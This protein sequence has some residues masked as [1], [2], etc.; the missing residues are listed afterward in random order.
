[1]MDL[2][3]LKLL[4]KVSLSSVHNIDSRA[5][6]LV[7]RKHL[8]V[9]L[10]R[11]SYS[12]YGGTE[13]QHPCPVLF[14]S[15]LYCCITPSDGTLGNSRHVLKHL[16]YVFIIR[17]SV[18]YYHYDIPVSITSESFIKTGTIFSSLIP[19]FPHVVWE[20]E[21][22]Q[23]MHAKWKNGRRHELMASTLLLVW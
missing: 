15:F 6:D 8:L 20:I 16:Q 17:T 12:E 5:S 4:P 11:F 1:M 3:L 21:G 23:N 10:C 7:Y 18:L 19:S 13:V 22:F 2:S 9:H 14:S